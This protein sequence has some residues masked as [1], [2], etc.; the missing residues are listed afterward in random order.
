MPSS[1]TC[2]RCHVVNEPS[3]TTCHSCGARFCPTCKL[4]IDSPSARVCPHCGKTDLSFKPGKY[5]D[6]TYVAPGVSTVS[7][8]QGYCSNCGSRIDPGVRKCP[9]CGRSGTMTTQAPHHA[10]AE[11]VAAPQQQKV[12]SK[13]GTP[14]PP[15]SSLCPIHGKFGGGSK[16]Q[17]GSEPLVPGRYTG[18]LWRRIEEKRAASAAAEQAKY[19]PPSRQR[20]HEDIYDRMEAPPA[21][22]QSF[23][24]PSETLDQ[25]ICPNC[26][27]PVPDRSKVCPNCG[28]NRLPQQKSRPIIKAEDYYKSRQTSGQPQAIYIPEPEP[29]YSQAAVMPETDPYY[30]QPAIMPET[31]PYYGQP[32]IMPRQPYEK[33]YSGPD[34]A[35]PGRAEK[36]RKREKR[37]K[38]PKD[39]AYRRPGPG[40][41]K[42]PWPMLLALLAL[43]GVIIIAGVLIFD[44]LKAPPA[45]V[46]PSSSNNPVTTASKPPVISNIQF[47]DISRAGATVTWTTDKKSNSIVV[48]CLDG[49]N[50]CENAKDD[51][52]VTAHSVKLTNLEH[53]KTYHITVKSMVNDVDASLDAPS[54]LRTTDVLD[55]TPPQIAGV[56]AVNLVSSGTMSS[57]TITW[58]TDEPATSQVSYGTSVGY[59]TLQPSQTD[60]TPVKDHSVLLQGLPT[61]TI[62]HYKVISRDVDG[63][64]SSSSDYTFITPPPAGSAIGNAAPDFTLECADG[65]EVTLSSLQGGK[66]IIN[67]WHT[68]CAPCIEEMPALQQLHSSNP[69]LPMLVIHGTALGPLNRAF[70]GTF[71]ADHNFTFTVPLDETGQVSS[72]YNIKNIPTT[73]FLD[74]SGIIRKVQVGSFSSP[75]EIESMLNSY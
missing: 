5:T 43:A 24:Q 51:A 56:K 4:V 36:K 31:D 20:P 28:W 59:G 39:E 72:L 70:L 21:D 48:Y 47:K 66:V 19:A 9:Y 49:G 69:S 55:T 74:S 52:L 23:S 68:N 44:M 62:I 17:G 50:L 34:Y 30:N 41:R 73:F 11:P 61:Q 3:A 27:S 57:A 29:Y 2:Q 42:S 67:F 22:S 46:L 10:Y 32:A 38:R 26:G 35:A 54:V 14:I 12:C 1:I 8:S 53:G 7:A 64:E 40:Q 60:T 6:G 58:T 65:K 18:D 71:L 15:G 37:E 16:L 13:C 45:P 75:N 33:T 25:R 63:N